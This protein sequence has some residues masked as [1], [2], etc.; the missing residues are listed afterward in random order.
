MIRQN[1]T[2]THCSLMVQNWKKRPLELMS[3]LTCNQNLK[4]KHPETA[5]KDLQKILLGHDRIMLRLYLGQASKQREIFQ[6][7]K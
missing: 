1:E 6:K 7:E 2:R 5:G 3:H 4:R